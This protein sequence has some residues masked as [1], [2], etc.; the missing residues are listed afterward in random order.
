MLSDNSHHVLLSQVPFD[1]RKAHFWVSGLVYDIRVAEFTCIEEAHGA[2][3]ADSRKNGLFQA[4]TYVVYGF[5]MCD[6]LCCDLLVL[7][8]P[9]GDRAV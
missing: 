4:E 9:Y 8:V 3:L 1:V 2:I 5:L 6:Q 7:Y